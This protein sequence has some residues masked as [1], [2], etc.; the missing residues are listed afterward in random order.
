MPETY[1]IKVANKSKGE[2]GTVIT[3]WTNVEGLPGIAGG[4][5]EFVQTKAATEAGIGIHEYGAV[6][7]P[8]NASAVTLEFVVNGVTYQSQTNLDPSADVGDSIVFAPK[9]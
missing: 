4:N 2:N 7:F 5:L 6:M 9:G 8:P 3:L 1:T